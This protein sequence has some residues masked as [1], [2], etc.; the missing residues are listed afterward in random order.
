M[1]GGCFDENKTWREG[2]NERCSSFVSCRKEKEREKKIIIQIKQKKIIMKQNKNKTEEKGRDLF[3]FFF[4]M[5]RKPRTWQS[6]MRKILR[7]RVRFVR[8][9]VFC[10]ARRY[11]RRNIYVT[12]EKIR[13]TVFACAI[14]HLFFFF[15]P[16]RFNRAYKNIRRYVCVACHARVRIRVVLRI[17][18]RARGCKYNN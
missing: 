7:W 4:G 13:T 3:F 11:P 18:V 8:V 6:C 5:K 9:H 16:F 1:Y 2:K 12:E 15:F 10:L 17:C 14:F